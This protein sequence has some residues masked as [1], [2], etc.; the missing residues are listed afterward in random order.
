MLIDIWKYMVL[1]VIGAYKYLEVH[2]TY[3]A[4]RYVDP[5]KEECVGK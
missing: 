5:I 1:M 2:G 4:Y 3:G